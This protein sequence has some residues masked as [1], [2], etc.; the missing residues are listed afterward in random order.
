MFRS[1][2]NIVLA[3]AV[4]NNPELDRTLEGNGGLVSFWFGA[5]KFI[6][7]KTGINYTKYTVI[8]TRF[9]SKFRKLSLGKISTILCRKYSI[10]LENEILKNAKLYYL[11]DHRGDNDGW[12]S[13]IL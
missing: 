10:A 12:T 5:F 8:W 3:I 7:G 1:F 6:R 11:K 13:V 4:T 2:N 9:Q